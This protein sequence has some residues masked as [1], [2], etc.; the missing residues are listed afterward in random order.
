MEHD[1]V[2]PLEWTGH[3]Y[4]VAIAVS[5]MARKDERIK[6]RHAPHDYVACPTSCGNAD[7]FAM[8]TGELS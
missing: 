3:G 8:W 4:I 7:W 5:M 1:R 6:I 2:V